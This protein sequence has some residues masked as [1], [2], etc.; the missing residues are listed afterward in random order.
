M[1]WPWL[2]WTFPLI[3][4]FF[5]MVI[6]CHSEKVPLWHPKELQPPAMDL[7]IEAADSICY[8]NALHAYSQNRWIECLGWLAQISPA[9]SQESTLN[10]YRA[11]CY[12]ALDQPDKCIAILRKGNPHDRWLL[13][14][15]LLRKGDGESAEPILLDL[16]QTDPIFGEEGLLLLQRI[17]SAP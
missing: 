16:I 12:L 7:S 9:D 11:V 10:R 15:A 13:A 1:H 14:L 4:D 8:I 3:F 2:G 5:A 17:H 6:A